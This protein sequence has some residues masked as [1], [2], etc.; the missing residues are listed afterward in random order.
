MNMKICGPKCSLCCTLISAWGIV[1]LGIMGILF[2]VRSPAFIEDLKIDDSIMHPAEVDIHGNAKRYLEAMD[3]SFHTI[4]LNCWIA[5][6]LYIVT[7]FLSGWQ[8]WVN[9]RISA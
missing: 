7:L 8:L 2:W 1:Q 9:N 6:L 4:A 3:D 5:A